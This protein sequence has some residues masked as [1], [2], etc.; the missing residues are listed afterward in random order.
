MSAETRNW[1]NKSDEEVV[2]YAENEEYV[3]MSPSEIYE[4]DRG[5]Y[6]VLWER[7]LL[8]RVADREVMNWSSKSDTEILEYAE[9]NDLAGLS[10]TELSEREP[11]LYNHILNE[12]EELLEEIVERELSKT[13]RLDRLSDEELIEYAEE[14]GYIGFSPTEMSRE[15]STF[16]GYINRERADIRDE[17]LD[18]EHRNLKGMTDEEIREYAE[19]ENYVGLQ[20]SELSK[21]D[22]SFYQELRKR[23]MAEDI[24]EKGQRWFSNWSDERIMEYARENDLVGLSPRELSEEDG[25]F[26]NHLRK[27]RENGEKLL[28]EIVER[29]RRMQRD[30]GEMSDEQVIEEAREQDL[31]GVTPT[32]IRRKDTQL[33]DQLVE[34]GIQDQVA[35]GG[36]RNFEDMNIDEKIEFAEMQGYVGMTASELHEEDPS[37]YSNEV[38]ES[39]ELREA[40]LESPY[41]C[42]NYWESDEGF[43]EAQRRVAHHIENEGELPNA[44]DMNDISNAASNGKFEDRGIESFGDFQVEVLVDHLGPVVQENEFNDYH[45]HGYLIRDRM[46][47]RDLI[48][49]VDEEMYVTDEELLEVFNGTDKGTAEAEGGVE[50]KEFSPPSEF[51]MF[52][53]DA[54]GEVEFLGWID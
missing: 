14:R 31:V 40:I 16:Y 23:D 35:K 28:D 26:Y 39:E 45:Y 43:E 20:P 19:K 3:G 10:P 27:N 7:D 37:F 49:E 21:E 36:R 42:N 50:D 11:G 32:E 2:E 30:W 41:K 4:K 22:G 13:E 8:D 9:E 51:A 18:I 5:F 38:M 44:E 48:T 33:A 46:L 24:L 54:E 34:R 47:E 17:I 25:G 52:T 29:E 12:R 6:G 53:E 1:T 15:D